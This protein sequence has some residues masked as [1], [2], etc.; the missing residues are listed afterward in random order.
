MAC[1]GLTI[2]TTSRAALHVSGERE[3]LVS[4]LALPDPD[5]LMAGDVANA[6]AVRLFAE[7]AMAVDPG[8]TLGDDNA[9][10]VAAICVRVDGLPLAIELAAA[11]SKVLAPPLLLPRLARRLPLLTGGPRDVPARL[12][13]MYDAI[14]WSYDLL[15]AEEQALFRRLAVFVGGFTLDAAEAISQRM[16]EASKRSAAP[17]EPFPDLPVMAPSALDR[18]ASL[19]DKN[20][21]RW[22]D[23]RDHERRLVMLE[24]LREFALERLAAM[25]DDEG[26]RAAHAAFF[27]AFAEQGYP[28]HFGP[29]PDID[30]RLQQLEAELPNLRAALAFMAEAGDAQD[31]LRLAGALAVFC[32]LRGHLREGRQWLE[33]ALAQ[34]AE[35]QTDAYCRALAGL[36]LIRWAQGEREQAVSPARAALAIAEQIDDREIAAHAVHVLG[37]VAEA[38]QRWEEAGPLFARALKLWRSLGAQAEEAVALTLLSGV[39]YWLGDY[40][41]A[42]SQAEASLAL[43][44]ALGYA[45]G[46]G[47][48]LCRLAWLARDR[49]DDHTAAVAY[50]EALQLWSNGNDRWFI[51]MALAG[52]AE[53]ASAQDA[54][55]LAAR[56]LGCIDAQ[57]E[58][59]GAPLFL[60]ARINHDRAANATCAALGGE[61]FAAIHAA[62]RQMPLM[63]AV[64]L[65]AAFRSGEPGGMTGRDHPMAS[66][67]A[68][69]NLTPREAEVLRRLVAGQ[70]DR[71][72][73]AAL[74]LSRRTVQDHVS[75]LL[76]K[77]GVANRTAAAAVAVRDHLI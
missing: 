19:V 11:R 50:H 49:G 6:P 62:G 34:N 47:L 15:T 69:S 33:W 29:F 45:H 26:A 72:I 25:G 27:V 14:A 39:S 32:Q 57:A 74:F 8:F 70:T 77:L 48:A 71:E 52:L 37:L 38:Q 36:G 46:T 51:V 75:H 13:T 54:S 64:A 35:A 68:T 66:P 12:Q 55:P 58:V 2:L 4:P 63:E 40:D 7:R 60:S 44:R 30:R 43:C 17:V 28:N 10:A 3:Y 42:T 21:L 20:L 18:I 65:A 9:A 76:A 61:Q 41:L 31:V 56:L 5:A 59:V 53:L 1:P 16:G 23:A 67:S 73:A 24:T 22:T